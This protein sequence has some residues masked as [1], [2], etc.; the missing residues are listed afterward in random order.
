MG[1]ASEREADVR[2]VAA[3]NRDLEKTLSEGRFR[4]DLYYRI[5]VV[6]IKIPSLKKRQE[7]IPLLI[8]HFISFYNKDTKNSTNLYSVWSDFINSS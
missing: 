3:T 4:E 6:N 7:D 2:I 1:E 5:N 8:N